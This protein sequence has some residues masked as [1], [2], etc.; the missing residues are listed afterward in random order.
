M[1]CS[2]KTIIVKLEVIE[3]FYSDLPRIN[4]EWN[5]ISSEIFSSRKIIS[6]NTDLIYKRSNAMYLKTLAGKSHE[7]LS[8]RHLLC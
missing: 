6:Q 1:H 8:N 5:Q 3:N 2:D 7:F 4:I